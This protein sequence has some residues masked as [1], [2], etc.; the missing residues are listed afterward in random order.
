MPATKNGGQVKMIHA[1]NDPCP[2][3]GREFGVNKRVHDEHEYAAS[4]KA[5]G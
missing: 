1:Q 4:H 3:G 5:T 2:I